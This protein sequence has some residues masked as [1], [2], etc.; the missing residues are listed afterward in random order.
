MK[1]LLGALAVVVLIAAACSSGTAASSGKLQ[2]VTTVSPITD[3][4]RNV[5]GTSADVHGII[6]EG[7][8]S[9]TFEPTPQ[10]AKLLSS[11]DL[12][13]LNGL[14]LEDPTLRLAEANHRGGATICLPGEHD[15]TRA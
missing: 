3:I 5:A 15:H 8:D 13:L 6:P 2:V 14:H 10:S 12:I 7:V 1:R 4:A 11:A 9:H